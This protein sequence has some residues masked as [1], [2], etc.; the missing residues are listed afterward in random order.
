MVSSCSRRSGLVG[1]IPGARRSSSRR[2]ATH[3]RPAAAAQSP[4]GTA[5]SFDRRRPRATISQLGSP[6]DASTKSAWATPTLPPSISSTSR[7]TQDSAIGPPTLEQPS[8]GARRVELALHD[9]LEKPAGL[10][11]LRR[12][13]LEAAAHARGGDA[14]D[15]V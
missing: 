2:W 13:R 11:V 3:T 10:L 8:G 7:P 14:E 15:L 12:G 4:I 6:L 5:T 1:S 9:P